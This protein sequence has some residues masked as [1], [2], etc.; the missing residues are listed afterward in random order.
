MSPFD[1]TPFPS[2]SR[3][4]VSFLRSD[5]AGDCGTAIVA[6]DSADPTGPPLGA[7]ARE[8]AVLTMLPASTSVSVTR[9]VAVHMT[10]CPGARTVSG[11][12]IAERP[13]MRSI[14]VTPVRVTLPLLE[15]VNAYVSV[16]PSETSAL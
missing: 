10:D 12:V 3:L 14:A 9:Y 11:Q 8:T 6:V 2:M 4:D 7:V 1:T 16:S 15:T 5:S 13:T